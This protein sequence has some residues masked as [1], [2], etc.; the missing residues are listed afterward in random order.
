MKPKQLATRV[1]SALKSKGFEA[2]TLKKGMPAMEMPRPAPGVASVR[3]WK[4]QP[5][6]GDD[7]S[8]KKG[9]STDG[10][11]AAKVILGKMGFRMTDRGS[12][13]GYYREDFGTGDPWDPNRSKVKAFIAADKHYNYLWFED[14]A[15]SEDTV[16]KYDALLEDLS[17]EGLEE[18][19]LEEGRRSDEMA[20]RKMA[21]PL[22]RL[23]M[24]KVVNQ[25]NPFGR[26]IDML[27]RD[28]N[29]L[30][31]HM[32]NL[33]Y[34]TGELANKIGAYGGIPEDKKFIQFFIG[35]ALI[36][37]ADEALRAGNNVLM[38]AIDDYVKKG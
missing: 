21:V 14:R 7:P 6:Q 22:A 8:Y 1:I 26:L 10:M 9:R 37:L 36:E 35:A 12:V 16:S 24:K 32:K 17:E 33:D 13:N 11:K 18:Q 28:E 5:M 3:F 38:D 4:R 23:R 29:M 27:F 30:K 34:A 20:L 2:Q 19:T 15:K 25:R 31:S